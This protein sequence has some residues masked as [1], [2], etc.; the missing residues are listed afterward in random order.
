MFTDKDLSQI[1]KRGSDVETVK[2]Q[3]EDFKS[4]FPFMQVL[5]AATV[6]DG[7]IR[8]DEAAKEQ[9]IALFDAQAPKLKLLKFVPASGAASRMFKS[10]FSAKDEGKTDKSVDQFFDQLSQFAFYKSLKNVVEG[11]DRQSVLD[12][13]LT[14]KGLDYGNLPKGLLEFHTYAD[15]VRTGVEEHLVEG[16]LYANNKGKVRLHFTVS[17]EHRKKFKALIKSVLSEYETA[18]NVKFDIGFSEQKPSTD[19]IAVDMNNEPFRSGD[20]SI[21]FRPAGHGA[22]LENLNDQEADVTFIKN[23]DNVVPDHLKAETIAYKKALAGVLLAYRKQIFTFAKRLEKDDV[24]AYMVNKALRFLRQELSV[25]P[26]KGFRNWSP[27]DKLAYARHK[28]NRPLRVCGMVK[29]VG[30]PGGGPFWAK[31]PDGS[32]SLQ[33]VESA[34]INMKNAKQKQL[35][36]EATHFNP[37]DL[38]C[39]TKNHKKEKFDLLKFRDPKTGFITEKSQSGKTLKAQELPGLWNGAMSDWNTLFVEVPLITF[40]PVKTVNDLLRKEHQPK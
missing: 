33:V 34:Q 2:Q 22:L 11:D 32:F 10:L 25:E 20:G 21:L 24:S 23:I 14:T 6:G 37:V 30:E 19:T 8:L 31:N 35:F 29:N 1:E 40:N 7:L 28:F 5:K 12:G 4:G 16:A 17:P 27:E 18:Y 9:Y 38:I 15:K 36:E 13:L 39:S 26:P 3:I